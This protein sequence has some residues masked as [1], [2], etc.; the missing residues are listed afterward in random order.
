MDSTTQILTVLI[1]LITLVLVPTVYT[2]FE[3]GIR[4]PF[5]RGTNNA[6]GARA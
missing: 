6:R 5:R 1:L 4:W 2:L 3:E